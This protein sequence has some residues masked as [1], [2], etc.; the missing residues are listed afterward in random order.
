[1]ASRA[2]I[3][4]LAR[5]EARRLLMHPAVLAGFALFVGPWL[6]Q[7]VT[8]DR[9]HRYPVLQD[10]SWSSQL[11]L[12]LPAAGVAIAASLGA[13]REHRHGVTEQFGVQVL[14]PGA[15]TAAHLLALAPPVLVAA[16][17]SAA[18]IGYLAA[19]PGA[20]GS[21]RFAEL[22]AAP[23]C[24]LL[25][26][27]VG[28]L[29][30]RLS[31][32]PVTAPLAVVGLAVFT[33]A[34]AVNSTSNW[35]WLAPVTVEP[36]TAAPLPMAALWR[37]AGW[38]LLWLAGVA[39]VLSGSALRRAGARGW[40]FRGTVVCGASGALLAASMQLGGVPSQVAHQR[41]ELTLHPAATQSCEEH[42]RVTYCAF[43]GFQAWIPAWGQ[44]ASGVLAQVP[45]QVAGER[46]AVRQRIMWTASGDGSSV[47]PPF[48]TWR[49]EDAAARTAGA[50]TVGTLWGDGSSAGDTASDE[51]AG[52]AT[53]FAYRVVSGVPAEGERITLLCRSRAAVTL[54]LAGQST[55]GSRQALRSSVSRSSGGLA[56]PLL[57]SASGLAFQARSE[58]LALSLLDRPSN[59]VG[60]R[61]RAN[62]ALLTSPE[63]S[64]DE[65]ARL[66][67]VPAPAASEV[68][69]EACS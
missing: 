64:V 24:V 54:W 32:S 46:Y 42:G 36:E 66:L 19:Q 12:L 21:V 69:G 33:L 25:A 40:W 58:Q 37:P 52:F 18:R 29:A 49:K 23:L 1:M 6:Y 13:L 28:V 14:T 68:A 5:V 31:T 62:W 67:G 60:A 34:A 38:H 9:G 4:A 55:P 27:A 41:A 43:P 48:A 61:L 16:F 51:V 59:E 26:G 63:T 47:V 11:L 65:A 57:G 56:F 17:L 50:V 44:V 2:A 7:S 10:A 30:A 15:R 45:T 39:A 53:R 35:R 20:A 22:G 8:G 3:L